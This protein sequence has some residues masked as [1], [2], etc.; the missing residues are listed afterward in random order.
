LQHGVAGAE[1]HAADREPRFHGT[2]R[3][4]EPLIAEARAAYVRALRG[5]DGAQVLVYESANELGIAQ[6]YFRDYGHLTPI[7]AALMADRL[8]AAIR[9]ERPSRPAS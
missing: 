4:T 5:L 6:R 9:G 2:W 3:H 1:R 8:A 7:G